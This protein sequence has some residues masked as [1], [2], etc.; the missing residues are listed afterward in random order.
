MTAA[1][2]A[3]TS[4][5]KTAWNAAGSMMNSVPSVPS[6][7]GNDCGRSASKIAAPGKRWPMSALLSPS[8]SASASRYTRA[9]TFDTWVAASEITAPP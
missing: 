8:S 1:T 9:L 4:A 7:C 2:R 6:A 3:G 5:A